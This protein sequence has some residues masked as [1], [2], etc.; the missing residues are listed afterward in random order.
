MERSSGGPAHR[1]LRF[2][3]TALHNASFVFH[4]NIA[5]LCNPDTVEKNFSEIIK[6]G[7]DERVAELESK[8]TARGAQTST[9][10]IQEPDTKKRKVT[11]TEGT[12]DE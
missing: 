10:E 6:A 1:E 8:K 9:A 3:F 12:P 11:D 4:E 5:D 7:I 2:F